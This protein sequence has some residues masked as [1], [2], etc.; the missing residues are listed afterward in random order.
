ECLWSYVSQA[1]RES[2][3]RSSVGDRPY[4]L[5]YEYQA[6]WGARH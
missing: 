4:G 6:S 1:I 5:F 3:P 2:E